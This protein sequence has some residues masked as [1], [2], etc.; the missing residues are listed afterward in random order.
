MVPRWTGRLT[1]GGVLVVVTVTGAAPAAAIPVVPP[2]TAWVLT[3]VDGAGV[4]GNGA[5][6]QGVLS[7]DGRFLAFVSTASNLVPGDTNQAADVFVKDLQTGV[8]ERANV[9]TAGVEANA[10]VQGPAAVSAGGRFVAFAS[11]A[12]NLV[13]NDRNAASDVFV[14]DRALGTTVRVSVSSAGAEAN[15]AS[16]QPAVSM[17][18]KVVAF[19]SKATNLA[20]ADLN[21]ASDVFVRDLRTSTTNLISTSSAGVRG[22]AASGD[23]SMTGDGRY[24]TYISNASNLVPGDTN[25]ASDVFLHDRTGVTTGLIS[26]DAN[27]GPA[28][29]ASNNAEVSSN[30]AWI[31]F[32]SFAPDLVA[33]DTNNRRDVFRRDRTTSV[34]ALVS[35]GANLVQ[36]N[37][38]SFTPS[39][40]DHGAVAFSSDA[41]NLSA[42]ADTNGMTDVFVGTAAWQSLIMSWTFYPAAVLGGWAPA[43]VGDTMVLTSSSAALAPNDT[44]NAPDVF[45]WDIRDA[46]CTSGAGGRVECDLTAIGGPTPTTVEWFVDGVHQQ[47]LDNQTVVRLTATCQP[48]TRGAIFAVTRSG[49]GIA[50]RYDGYDCYP[51]DTQ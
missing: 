34:T 40:S 15:A 48:D 10:A 7:A 43:I 9:S 31:A 3:S 4:L 42:P 26:V 1:A 23:P 22:N 12:S 47:P 29:G 24:V 36:G 33:S 8:T 51:P 14:R 49:A 46:N 19:A 41:T 21:A 13:P 18:G 25:I 35:V 38:D 44:N 37:G 6:D 50:T 20:P 32:D 30:G 28:N 39:V 2:L 5:S 27:G 45:R 11:P 16:S 17:D